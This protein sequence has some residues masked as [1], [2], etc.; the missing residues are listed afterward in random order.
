MFPLQNPLQRFIDWLPDGTLAELAGGLLAALIIFFVTRAL[1][2]GRRGYATLLGFWQRPGK[3]STYRKTLEEKT[4]KINHS[5]MKEEQTLD[6]ILVP[7]SFEMHGGI[8]TFELDGFIRDLFQSTVAPRVLI[9]GRPGTGKS[10]AMRVIARKIWEVPTVMPL[11]PVLLTFTDLKG[12]YREEQLEAEIVEKLKLYQFNGGKREEESVEK[13]V[14][15]ELYAGRLLLLIDGFDEVEKEERQRIGE[16]LNIFLGT[17][18]MIPAILSSRV[19]VYQKDLAFEGLQPTK[20]QMAPFTN[21]AILRFLTQWRFEA[22]K[23]A[24]ELYELIINQDRAQLAELASNPLMLTIIAFLYSLP[25]YKLPDNRVEFYEQ[26]TSALLEEWDRDQ[27]KNRPNVYFTHQKE[28]VLS[29]LA[30]DQICNE[31]ETDELIKEQQLYEITKKEMARLSLKVEDYAALSEEIILNSGLLQRIPPRDFRFPHRTFMEFFAARYIYTELDHEVLLQLY[32]KDPGKWKEVLLL[33]LGICKNKASAQTVLSTLKQEFEEQL[34]S[35]PPQYNFLLFTALRDCAVPEPAMA[36][37]ILEL[38]ELYLSQQTPTSELIEELG[39]IAANQHWVYSEKATAILHALL[40]QR[41]DNATFQQVVLSVLHARRT[42]ADVQIDDLILGNIRRIDLTEFLGALGEK[43]NYFIQRFF[44]LRLD[45]QQKQ[46]LFKGMREAGNLKVLG[47]LFLQTEEEALRKAVAYELA[48]MSRLETFFPF[49]D[50][51]EFDLLPQAIK[52]FADEKWQ[53]WGWRWDQPH[54]PSGQKL[55][56]LIT[57]FSAKQLI[58]NGFNE[59]EVLVDHLQSKVNNRILFLL[60][61]FLVELGKSFYEHN[62]IKN[63]SANNFLASK[64]DLIRHWKR[65]NNFQQLW[66]NIVKHI[67]EYVDVDNNDFA[68]L[69]LLSL[70]NL[71]LCFLGLFSLLR[72]KTKLSFGISFTNFDAIFVEYWFVII[73][74]SVIFFFLFATDSDIRARDRIKG[75]LVGFIIMP[76]LIIYIPMLFGPKRKNERH[77]KNALLLST[78]IAI[79]IFALIIYLPF[80][81][82]LIVF[83]PLLMIVFSLLIFLDSW[84]L[85][86][87]FIDFSNYNYV[88]SFLSK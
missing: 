23:S 52:Q 38:A 33:Y 82:I 8:K 28:A 42:Q 68:F 46:E 41:L 39:F 81:N 77:L 13:F 2:R 60:N 47:A 73:T 70:P 57:Y 9:L 25:K 64:N 30:Y 5:W 63:E 18:R 86:F 72:R 62:L 15:E 37:S 49:L 35:D 16:F 48:Q 44:S 32:S 80:T 11:I 55:A 69:F 21:F 27:S 67:F 53:D 50:Q 85:R 65:D 75:I 87:N 12:K 31:R 59:K 78:F 36:F 29:H 17:Y 43:S 51:A 19:A 76:A 61:I 58:D 88:S 79:F 10:I 84:Q 3:L 40:E 45:E 71:A 56:F 20:I 83:L 24:T 34:V 22:P 7:V 66:K 4:L 54:T 1:I 6:D 14:K 26:C 74:C